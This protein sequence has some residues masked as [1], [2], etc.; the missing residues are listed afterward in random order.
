[1]RKT[2]VEPAVLQIALNGL[3]IQMFVPGTQFL[4]VQHI[5][6]VGKHDFGSFHIQPAQPGLHFP[7]CVVF[8]FAPFTRPARGQSFGTLKL[9]LSPR[10]IR[11]PLNGTGYQFVF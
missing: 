7:L 8:V 9:D 2:L 3:A 4:P 5:T 10:I 11:I 1:M 6:P